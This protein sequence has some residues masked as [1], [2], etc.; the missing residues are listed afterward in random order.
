MHC[1]VIGVG[2]LGLCFALT[3]E[4]AGIHVIGVD[5]NESYVSSLNQKTLET[6]EP[7]VC[8][9]LKTASLF[10]ATTNLSYAVENSEFVF[11]LVQTPE[12]DKS[13]DHTILE[14]LLDKIASMECDPKHIIINSTV[15]PGFHA[16]HAPLL[17]HT[18]SYNPAF[19]AQ[20]TVMKDYT[21]GGKFNVVVIG[22]EDDHV[23]RWLTDIYK[24][25]NPDTHI[26]VM[27]PTSAEIFK[28][29]DNTFRV[30]KIVYANMIADIC[31]K[32]PG[33][34]VDEVAN[35]L[36]N[37]TSIGSICM[38]PGYGYGGPCYPRD[39]RA[40]ATYASESGVDSSLLSGAQQV[41][42]YHHKAIVDEFIAKNLDEYVFENP[43]YRLDMLVPMIDNSP[44]LRVAIDLFNMGKNVVIKGNDKLC[45]I[46][47]KMYGPKIKTQVVS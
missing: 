5:L 29:A 38:T 3:L 11:I 37:D 23:R 35:A 44:P 14:N 33:A 22:T 10:Q 2:K 47:R 8:E 6:D 30:I 32:S 45:E 36:K 16:R 19:V 25:I 18:L 7:G 42:E 17:K 46:I 9:A 34:V 24:K 13:Y 41:N 28:I 40:L 31:N 43:T 4:K 20:G 39:I 26:N 21:D 1:A 27:K 12:T 15:M